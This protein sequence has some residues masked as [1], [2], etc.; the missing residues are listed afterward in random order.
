MEKNWVLSENSSKTGEQS[1]S[2]KL[3]ALLCDVDAWVTELRFESSDTL[4]S[5]FFDHFTQMLYF[6]LLLPR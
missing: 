6:S 5:F 2:E 1:L 3:R 4:R